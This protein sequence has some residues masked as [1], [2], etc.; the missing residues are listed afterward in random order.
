IRSST[1]AVRGTS[2]VRPSLCS[3]TAPLAPTAALISSMIWGQSEGSSTTSPRR[4]PTRPNLLAS[5]APFRNATTCSYVAPRL[6]DED[7]ARLGQD[8]VAVPLYETAQAVA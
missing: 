1:L 8:A 5:E 4:A 2:A 7:L 6:Q 3:R